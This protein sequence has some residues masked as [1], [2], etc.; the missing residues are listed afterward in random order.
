MAVVNISDKFHKE[1]AQVKLDNK[2]KSM[3]EALEKML[4]RE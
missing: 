4:G 1:I 3:E 2:L